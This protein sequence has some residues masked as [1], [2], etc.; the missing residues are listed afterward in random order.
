MTRTS[1]LPTQVSWGFAFSHF[2][3]SSSVA[4]QTPKEDRPTPR[5]PEIA[6]MEYMSS[7]VMKKQNKHPA[8]HGIGWRSVPDEIYD[9][10]F[11]PADWYL[12]ELS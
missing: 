6:W 1:D 2:S 9:K 12:E 10:F 8:L 4:F 11:A 5:S 7:D 3:A